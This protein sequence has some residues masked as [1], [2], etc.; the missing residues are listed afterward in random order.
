MTAIPD[1]SLVEFLDRPITG[2]REDLLGR[3][4]FVE[5]VARSLRAPRSDESA[6]VGICGPWGCGKSSLKNLI[7]EELGEQSN[8][9][10]VVRFEPWLLLDGESVLR[11]LLHTL[12]HAVGASEHV[13]PVFLSFGRRILRFGVAAS[14]VVA[15]LAATYGAPDLAVP[16]QSI[17]NALDAVQAA[18]LTETNEASVFQLKTDLDKALRRGR[19]RFLVV[20]DELDRLDPSGIQWFFQAIKAALSFPKVDYLLFFQRPAIEAAFERSGIPDGRRYLEKLVPVV[21][22][23]PQIAGKTLEDV[24]VSAINSLSRRS[25]VG[26]DSRVDEAAELLC[27]TFVSSIRDV[28]RLVTGFEFHLAAH[29]VDGVLEVDPV[30][31]LLLESLRLFEPE[32]HGSL[33][34][35]KRLLTESSEGK[36]A[37][38]VDDGK[39]PR[40]TLL[41]ES[42]M[43]LARRPEAARQVVSMLFPD[44]SEA[45]YQHAVRDE[46]AEIRSLRICVPQFFDRYFLLRLG[47]AEL[48]RSTLNRIVDINSSVAEITVELGKM[49]PGFPG[50]FAMDRLRQM[51][52]QITPMAKPVL[53]AA[54][55]EFLETRSGASLFLSDRNFEFFGAVR[56]SADILRSLHQD[57]ERRHVLLSALSKTE[58]F[59]LGI[60]IDE[61]DS[62]P[63]SNPR[64]LNEALLSELRD[65]I[66]TRLLK[67]VRSAAYL[68]DGPRCLWAL[69]WW[70]RTGDRETLRRWF[71]SL[72]EELF[73]ALGRGFAQGVPPI[74]EIRGESNTTLARG[75]RG[76]LDL[77]F[78][79]EAVEVRL[80][81]LR[82]ELPEDGPLL[83]ILRNEPV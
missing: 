46:R 42:V 53:L 7:L 67:A 1:Q 73:L 44:V 59:L 43:S 10:Q 38:V 2:A 63:E 19:H 5:G 20:V 76:M 83:R 75:A 66:R 78:G 39:K 82:S 68:Q 55:F 49:Q 32:L 72:D 26:V 35:A 8:D 47:A 22:D 77:F 56:L 27:R 16:A 33:L 28:K 81:N 15:P 4:S 36:L 17:G 37:W 23:V 3:R 30:D 9:L 24:L 18:A 52:P 71:E 41:N 34:R 65:A 25:G 80:S 13:R 31:L 12:A 29:T 14:R 74:A 58:A 70:Y 69:E 11:E 54:L 61:Y 6:V 40:S 48:S 64:V 51:I 57:E 79:R 62:A 50:A 21:L 60:A 45:P